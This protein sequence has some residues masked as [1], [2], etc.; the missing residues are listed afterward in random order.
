MFGAVQELS[1]VE[2]QLGLVDRLTVCESNG[3]VP[4]YPDIMRSLFYSFI[5]KKS[6]NFTGGPLTKGRRKMATKV[7]AGKESLDAR[8]L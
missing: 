2:V 4:C 3:R 5:E 6:F 7:E 8:P 1:Y